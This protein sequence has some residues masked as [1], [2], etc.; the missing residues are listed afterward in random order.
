MSTYIFNGT[1]NINNKKG[2]IPNYNRGL[3]YWLLVKMAAFVMMH[4]Q[5]HI[6]LNHISERRFGRDVEIEA[7]AFAAD[8]L[9]SLD[10]VNG[11]SWA[12]PIWAAD[13]VLVAPATANTATAAT[14]LDGNKYTPYTKMII[15]NPT[16]HHSHFGLL[17]FI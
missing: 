9:S 13:L 14:K 1:P 5:A 10:G 4:E 8:A 12:V 15:R 2:A 16:M 11:L 17:I 6:G 3:F 7:D